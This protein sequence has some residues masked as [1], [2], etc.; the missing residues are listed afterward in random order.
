MELRLLNENE[1]TP[2]KHK[3]KY[4]FSC[5]FPVNF[6]MKDFFLDSQNVLSILTLWFQHGSQS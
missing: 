5:G 4:F 2:L 6:D 1:P 3:S